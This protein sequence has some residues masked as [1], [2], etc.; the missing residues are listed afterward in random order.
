MRQARLIEPETVILE[1]VDKPDPGPDQ[2][3]I[4]V[5]RIGVCGSDIHAYYDK[6]PYIECPIVQGHEFS[7]EIAELGR[8]VAGLSVGDRV[9]V[10]PQLVCGFCFSC[11]KGDYHIC[12]ELK[13][14]GCQADGAAREFIAVD[15]ELVVK[16]PDEI[17]FDHGAMVEPVAVGVHAVGRLGDVSG[18]NILVMGA[19]P[20]G[21]LTAQAALG[22]GAKSVLISDISDFRLKIAC[23]CGI[24]LT[25]NVSCDSMGDALKAAFGRDGATAIIECVGTEETM[26]EAVRLSRKGSDIVIVGVF[27]DKSMVD[28]GLVQD[29]E[30]RLIGTLMYKAQDYRTA[31]ELIQAGKIDLY[32]LIDKHFTLEEYPE[33]YTYIER[34]RDRTMKV[35]IDL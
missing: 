28:L 2:V 4:K 24:D 5:R 7:G 12:N 11:R 6:H 1:E 27:A 29:K 14:I 13:V 32:P 19:G 22:L 20:I 34:Q 8:E 30:L 21:N 9:T 15:H 16:L 33:A 17:S 26:A 18:M 35:I 10:M 31:I 25:V 23:L 3:L